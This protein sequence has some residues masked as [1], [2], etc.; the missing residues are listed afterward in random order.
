MTAPRLAHAERVAAL[1][2][3][4][5]A[6]LRL[7]ERERVLWTAAGWLHDAL[8]DAP[9][10]E[11]RSE[12]GAAYADWP[13]GALHGPAAA[14]RLTDAPAEL[15]QGIRHH[16]LGAPAL[17]RLGRALYVADFVEPGRDFSPE[18]TARLRDRLPGE[19]EAVTREVVAA[20]MAHLR[21]AGKPVHPAT[22]A[23]ADSL[24]A[25]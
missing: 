5:A 14:E 3:G 20:R 6:A 16:T 9:P 2:G 18:W 13:D 7:G 10:E 21:A 12:L 17:G 25:G 19:L 11:L 8:R 15:R 22:Q 4:W 1:L 23:F 24:A